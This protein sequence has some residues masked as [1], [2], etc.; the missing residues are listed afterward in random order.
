MRLRRF[1]IALSGF[2]AGLFLTLLVMHVASALPPACPPGVLTCGGSMTGGQSTPDADGDGYAIAD[3]DCDDGNPLRSPGRQEV[4]GNFL[5]DDCDGSVDEEGCAQPGVVA[6]SD[7]TSTMVRQVS[8]DLQWTAVAWAGKSVVRY[9]VRQS[10]AAIDAVSWDTATPLT[11]TPIPGFAGMSEMYTVVGLA[12]QTKYFFA[13]R[14]VDSTGNLSGVSNLTATTTLAE[15]QPPSDGQGEAADRT[16]P[17][18]VTDLYAVPGYSEVTLRW[19][20][21][22]DPDVVRVALVRNAERPPLDHTDGTAVFDGLAA[23][24]IDL[25][26]VAGTTYHY[27]AFTYDW[28]ANYAAPA[29]TD[30]ALLPLPGDGSI[31]SGTGGNGGD[32]SST[33]SGTGTDAGT[34]TG[35][36]T[37]SGTNTGSDT[38]SVT[39]YLVSG[40]ELHSFDSP[41]TLTSLGVDPGSVVALSPAAIAQYRRGAA[42][43]IGGDAVLKLLDPDHDGLN[44]FDEVQARTD[45]TNPDTDYDSY[46]D[47]QE[48]TTGHDPLTV[49]SAPRVDRRLV[50]RMR[51]KILLQVERQGQAWWVHPV[52]GERYYLRDGKVAYQIMRF[53]S[54]GITSVDLAKIPRAGT[55]ETGDAALVKR[56]SGQMLLDVEN[57]GEAWYLN[58]ADGKRYYLRDGDAA[59]WLMRYRSLGIMNA[60]LDKIPIGSLRGKLQ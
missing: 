15:I 37:G 39:Y 34:G 6:V 59:Y 31:V 36:D 22:Q 26:A 58:P 28:N 53:L 30:A 52:T 56:L 19:T 47:G 54:L 17:P 43:T 8:I 60:N 49:P 13:V 40:G 29:R 44:N 4:C 50:D 32:G 3:G 7:L 10:P 48:Y 51:G 57:L 33:G 45:P 5:D 18:P 1:A 27:A 20:V 46:F 12:P 9:D 21:P 2:C 42:V 14:L 38:G 25:T 23:E 41:T 35:A 16:P 55:T 24:Y 11:G